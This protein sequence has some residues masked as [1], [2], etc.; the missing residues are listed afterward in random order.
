MDQGALESRK[1]RR[2]RRSRKSS[3][4]NRG[5]QAAGSPPPLSEELTQSLQSPDSLPHSPRSIQTR[6]DFQYGL[7]GVTR[8]LAAQR[9]APPEPPR[10]DPGATPR[11]QALF[12]ERKEQV[13]SSLNSAPNSGP[14]PAGT[15]SRFIGFKSM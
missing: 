9:A 15:L 10:P 5:G 14:R 12:L 7:R 13:P 11:A 8:S 3:Y 2:P 6:S 1:Q 4:L